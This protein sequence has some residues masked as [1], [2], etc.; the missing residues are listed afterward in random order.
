[1]KIFLNAVK[2]SKGYHFLKFNSAGHLNPRQLVRAQQKISEDNGCK[3]IR[4]CVQKIKLHESQV[5][6]SPIILEQKV[7]SSKKARQFIQLK[8]MPL[9]YQT[10]GANGL[11][12]VV[13]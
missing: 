5:S 6:F 13:P 10:D 11:S 2:M 1:M 3:I 12:L 9:H 7:K 4:E 8:G